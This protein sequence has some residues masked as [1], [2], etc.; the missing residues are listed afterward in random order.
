MFKTRNLFVIPAMLF[1]LSCTSTSGNVD[2]SDEISMAAENI[3]IQL[4]ENSTLTSG[5]IAVLPFVEGES[6]ETNSFSTYLTDELISALFKKGGNAFQIMERSQVDQLLKEAK[7]ASTGLISEDTA[8]QLGNMIGV[9]GLIIGSFQRISDKV[10]INSRLVSIETGKINS[11]GDGKISFTAYQ[12]VLESMKAMSSPE[13]RESKTKDLP[14]LTPGTLTIGYTDYELGGYLQHTETNP[15]GLDPSLAELIAEDLS[16]DTKWVLIP[17]NNDYFQSI[18]KAL[19]NNMVDMFISTT[20]IFEE[21]TPFVLF[22]HPYI[23]LANNDHFAIS[24]KKGNTQLK[25][26]IDPIIREYR[27][28]G[29]IE[30]LIQQYLD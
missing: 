6:N 18:V 9:E 3:S 15:V 5:S 11:V 28:N 12:S 29:T 14:T 23:E 24:F 19:N 21:R 4:M 10:K 17:S 16:L 20:S 22:S 26:A 7:F 25:D 13:S 8:V 1:I 30:K 2:S 27:K